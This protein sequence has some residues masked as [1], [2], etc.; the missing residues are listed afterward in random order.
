MKNKTRGIT[1]IALVVTIVV[2]LILAA[3]SISMLTGENGIIIR[4]NQ[5]SKENTHAT[6]YES[7][8][9]EVTNYYTEKNLEN[10]TDNLIDYLK[11]KNIIDDNMVINV[12]NLVKQT[13]SLGK[14]NLTDGDY[15]KLEEIIETG[16]QSNQL[17]KIASIKD[18]I[19]AATSD[20]TK[21][22]KIVYYGTSKMAEWESDSISASQENVKQSLGK[23]VYAVKVGDYI[24]YAPTY[25]NTS[26]VNDGIGNGWRVAYVDSAS[27]KVTLVSEGVPLSTELSNSFNSNVQ[28]INF[29]SE[30]IN[31]TFDDTVAD[32]IDILTLEDIQLLCNQAGYILTHEEANTS[33][34]NWKVEAY[35]FN[36]DNLNI[37]NIG[38]NY[39]LNTIASDQYGKEHYL[40]NQGGNDS[41]K[42]SDYNGNIGVR[43]VV[44][45]KSDLEYYG[46][47]GTQ[48]NPYQIY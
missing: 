44:D 14:G 23:L 13:L 45:L 26:T 27:G 11:N 32:N 25:T 40:W 6:V 22:Y 17:K 10:T 34:G 37:L 19:V 29:D 42:A 18:I 12:N 21:Q 30:I 9:L 43:I 48:E 2:L 1:L 35:K 3:V 4:A 15:Y 39:L 8:L 36:I 31:Q 46:G 47:T 41:F 38:A 20:N 33:W 16:N 24:N 7:L 28:R 5:A